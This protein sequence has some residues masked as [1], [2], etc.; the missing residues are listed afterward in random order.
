MSPETLFA[1]TRRCLGD[2]LR[3]RGIS[4]AIREI[5][6]QAQGW[7][8]AM[9][10]LW[11]ESH[12]W[13]G[14]WVVLHYTALMWSRRGFPLAAPFILGILKLRGCRTAVIFHDVYAIAGPRWVDRIR[15][16]FQERIMRHL[17]KSAVRAILPVPV[18]SAPGC[19]PCAKHIYSRWSERA[20]VG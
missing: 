15:I 12:V 2:A 16:Y 7:F 3:R 4:C 17:S 13:R 20:L 8:A 5:R 1:I 6:W 19:R 9:R 14:Q 10:E 18:D 11:N